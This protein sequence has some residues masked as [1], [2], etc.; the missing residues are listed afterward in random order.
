MK[1]RRL[2]RLLPTEKVG[3]LVIRTQEYPRYDGDDH[4]PLLAFSHCRCFA[5]TAPAIVFFFNT[6]ATSRHRNL[7]FALLPSSLPWIQSFFHVFL[8]FFIHR[9]VSFSS[10]RAGNKGLP[11][12]GRPSSCTCGTSCWRSWRMTRTW[13]RASSSSSGSCRGRWGGVDDLFGSRS[14]RR[15]AVRRHTVVRCVLGSRRRLVLLLLLLS[16]VVVVELILRP[17]V[18]ATA[19]RFCATECYNTGLIHGRRCPFV[20]FCGWCFAH[21]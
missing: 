9:V 1:L 20:V 21:A 5:L 18:Q 19:W 15:Q 8:R 3:R 7:S 10:S 11:R 16:F 6:G 13:W 2:E 14:L 4:V 12:L 17:S